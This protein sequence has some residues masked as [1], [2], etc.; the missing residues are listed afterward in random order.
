MAEKLLTGA[1]L[2]EF[3]CLSERRIKVMRQDGLL[4]AYEI[5][6]HTFRFR[7][8]ECEAALQKLRR[9]AVSGRPR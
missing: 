8:S 3:Y 1:Q 6:P 9:K 5:G 2:A 7:L 4:P